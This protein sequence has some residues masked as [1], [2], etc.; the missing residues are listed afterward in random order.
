MRNSKLITLLGLGL[1]VATYAHA[2]GRPD[3]NYN[4]NTDPGY[5][6]P[7]G[8]QGYVD[9]GQDQGYGDQYGAPAYVGPPPVC[10][11]GYYDYYP[12]ACVPYGYYGPSWFSGGVFI[13]VGPWGRG[14]QRFYGGRGFGGRGYFGGG[15]AFSGRG[16]F[17]GGFGNGYAGGGGRSFGSGG[18]SFSGGGRAFS[19]GGHS[20]GGGGR[21]S[22]GAAEAEAAMVVG[23]GSLHH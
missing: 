4:P 23:A 19:G 1:M 7:G 18:R 16:G 6:D 10:P 14:W 13:G 12:Y 15:Q 8:N 11:Y 5:V 2:Q 20:S 21:S 17:R 9:P 3:P 22:G